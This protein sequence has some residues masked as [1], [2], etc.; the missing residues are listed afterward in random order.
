MASA[1]PPKRAFLAFPWDLLA[2]P[3]ETTLKVM[4]DTYLSDAVAIAGSSHQAR[5]FNPRSDHGHYMER[6]TSTL[7]F[8]PDLSLYPP[9]GPWPVVDPMTADPA[10]L[11]QARDAAEKLDMQ[12][13]VWLVTLHSSTLGQAHPDLCAQNLSG[14][15]YSFSLCPSQPRVR[16]YAVGLLRDICRQVHPHTL[17][18]ESASFM[19]ASHASYHSSILTP[20]GETAQWLLGLCFCSSC[21]ARA[22]ASDVD[23]LGALYDARQLLP[24]LLSEGSDSLPDA[25]QPSPLSAILVGWPRLRAYAEMRMGIVTSL[26]H[27]MTQ[28]ARETGARVEVIVNAD[29]EHVGHAWTLGLDIGK[30]GE[31]VDGAIVQG[32]RLSR[33]SAQGETCSLRALAPNLPVSVTLDGGYPTTP[34]RDTL[35]A[36]ALAA[37]EASA[38]AIRYQNWG[39]LSSQRLDWVRAAN[40]ALL[41]LA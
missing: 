4:Q 32:G 5:L 1:L 8:Q 30:L 19:P 21:L 16:G 29:L 7:A 22:H 12:F 11:T 20:I 23:A 33:G 15:R 17:I 31:A 3:V 9:E 38:Q 36:N 39:L 26:L 14:D 35:V 2:E 25:R 27:E 10:I 13:D 28:V 34:D 24:S 40:A 18:L 41:G 37:A 6:P